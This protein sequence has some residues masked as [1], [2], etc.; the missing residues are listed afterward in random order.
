MQTDWFLEVLERI[1]PVVLLGL[2]SAF[3]FYSIVGIPV[4]IILLGAAVALAIATYGKKS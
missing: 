3:Y 1:V 4:G 2:L